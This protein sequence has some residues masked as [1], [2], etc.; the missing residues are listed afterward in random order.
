[1]RKIM[2]VIFIFLITLFMSF[3]LKDDLNTFDPAKV[4]FYFGFFL[5]ICYITGEI[6][7]GFKFPK[8]TGYILSGILFGPYVL[9]IIDN[10]IIKSL[11]LI[12]NLA[13]T[14]IAMVAGGELIIIELKKKLKSILYL[15]LF[16]TMFVIIG[17]FTGANLLKNLSPFLKDLN[18]V[19]VIAVCLILATI[20]TARSPSSAI[21]IIN[22]TKASGPYTR[23]VLGVTVSL[24]VITIILFAAAISVAEILVIPNKSIDLNYILLLFFSLGTSILIGILIGFAVSFYI[25]KINL[26]LPVLLLILA[27]LITKISHSF[28]DIIVHKFN[29]HFNLEPLLIA[30]T[31]GFYVENFAKKGQVFIQSLEK[32]SLIIYVIF[33]GLAGANLKID[34]LKTAWFLGLAIF[35]IRGLMLITSSYIAGVFSKDP[36][37]F[38]KLTGIGLITQ[39]G[40]SIGLANEVVRRFPDWGAEVATIVIAVI[41]LNQIVGPV[42][43]KF[44]LNKIGETFKS[45]Y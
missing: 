12:D 37:L 22:E 42:T 24:D 2:S 45:K 7:A 28:S 35:F 8:I 6:F 13:L 18:S 21:A 11:K 4:T 5:M 25:E 34:V 15:L 19:S 44:A 27:F 29:F 36:P 32:S 20:S 43:F 31:V 14:Y 40:V 41:T 10:D 16:T 3:F 9:G 1:M 26:D 38:R 30:I 33:F 23:T 39:A 17:V